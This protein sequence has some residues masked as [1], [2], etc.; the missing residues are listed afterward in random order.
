[1]KFQVTK[2]TIKKLRDNY[3]RNKIDLSPPYQRNFIWTIPDQQ[4]LI[5]SINRKNPIPNFFLLKRDNGTYEMVDGQQRSRTILSFLDGQFKDFQGRLFSEKDHPDFL[6]YEF[7]VTI[8]TDIENEDIEKFY[9]TVNKTGIHLNKA[10]VRKADFYSTNILALIERLSKLPEIKKLKLFSEKTEKRMNDTEFIAELV[11]L[12]KQ[13]HVD[14]KKILDDYFK[15]D[16]TKSECDDIEKQFLKVLK[17]IVKFNE[18][19]NISKTRYKQR[20]DFYTLFDFLI[21]YGVLSENTL[22]YFYKT[23]VLIGVD[24]KPTQ[25]ECEPLKEYA[26]NCITQS[27]SKKARQARLAF[28]EEL[29]INKNR[30]LNKTQKAIVDFYEVLGSNGVTMDSF[31]VLDIIPLEKEKGISFK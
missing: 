13:G 2:W 22:S 26:R 14:K 4:S 8:I 15:K 10:E 9:A 7:P 29:F 1:M 3:K 27:N 24:I 11:V 16:L 17:Q 21:K 28:F 30:V 23:L 31:L 12:I 5:D 19:F 18:T 6:V 25:D 20:N